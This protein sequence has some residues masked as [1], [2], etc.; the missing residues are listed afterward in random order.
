MLYYHQSGFRSHHSALSHMAEIAE[1]IRKSIDKYDSSIIFLFEL[2]KD[3][4]KNNKINI[5]FYPNLLIKYYYH[6]LNL[7]TSL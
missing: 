2:S 1:E 3:L 5:L 6:L 7:N 4:F